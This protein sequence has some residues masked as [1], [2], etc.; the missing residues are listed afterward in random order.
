MMYNASLTYVATL[1]KTDGDEK[2][3]QFR[4]KGRWSGMVGSE[5]YFNVY[6]TSNNL[7]ETSVIPEGTKSITI[8]D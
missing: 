2:G 8:Q 1:E 5:F 7:I 3:K 6:D 4:I